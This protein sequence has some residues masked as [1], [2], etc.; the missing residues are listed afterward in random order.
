VKDVNF[1]EKIDFRTQGLLSRK[2]MA[3]YLSISERKLSTMMTNR[4]IPFIKIGR[5]VRFNLSDVLDA[6]QRFTIEAN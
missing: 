3:R 4:E 6:L 2:E 1:Q 5:S